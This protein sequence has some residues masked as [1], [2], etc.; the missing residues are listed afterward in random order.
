[1]VV[2]LFAKE[3]N[4]EEWHDMT[5]SRYALLGF[6][7]AAIFIAGRDF[8]LTW[9]F[10][11]LSDGDLSW[12][13]SLRV[14]LLCEFT[15][16]VTPTAV[17]GSAFSLYFMNREGLTLGRSTTLMMTTLFFD[18]LIFVVLCP[19]AILLV[20]YAELL[21]RANLSLSWLPATFWSVYVVIAVWTA[22]LFIGIVIRPSLVTRPIK[23]LFKLPVIKRWGKSADKLCDD[24]NVTSKALKNKRFLW[25]VKG[26]A[27]T[28]V[29]WISRFLL[30]NAIILVFIPN[31]DQLLALCRQVAVWV[32]LMFAPTPGG[33]GISEGLFMTYYGDIISTETL[34]LAITIVWRLLSYYIYLIIGVFLLPTWLAKNRSKDKLTGK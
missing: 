1:M 9:R 27:A 12:R 20:P 2:W 30:V 34:A 10:R 21:F 11:H 15:S 13:Q 28:L 22:I 23:A 4:L 29:S 25:W 7:F 5:F 18:E 6:L 8:G 14:C 24:M 31:A 32:V 16:A 19:I 3:F 33:A 17:G 26:F